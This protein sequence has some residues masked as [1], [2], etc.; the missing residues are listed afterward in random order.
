MTGEPIMD[1]A[2]PNL[3]RLTA[4][5]AARKAVMAEAVAN[6]QA[7]ARAAADRLGVVEEPAPR[8]QPS[9]DEQPDSWLVAGYDKPAQHHAGRGPVGG[10]DRLESGELSWREVFSPTTTDRDARA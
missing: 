10:L 4:E 1:R 3:D 8:E 5:F 6:I 2:R 9:D 7:Q